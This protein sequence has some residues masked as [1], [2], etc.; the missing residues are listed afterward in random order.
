[1]ASS[2]LGRDTSCSSGRCVSAMAPSYSDI[3]YLCT[4]STDTGPL[5]TRNITSRERPV[6]GLLT[7]LQTLLGRGRF[8]LFTLFGLP[9]GLY[10]VS[11]LFHMDCSL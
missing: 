4:L 1:M 8:S 3:V 2:C 9:S 10:F 7:L 6:R 5:G 11:S